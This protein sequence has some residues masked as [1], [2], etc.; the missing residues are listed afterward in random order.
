MLATKTDRVPAGAQWL[1]EVKWDGVRVLVDVRDGVVRMTSRNDNDVTPAWPDLSDPPLGDRDLLVD[2][3]VIALNDRGVPDFRVLQHRMHVRNARE[4]ARLVKSV[5]ATLMVFDLL[6]LDGVD[7]TDRPLEERRALLEEL[8]LAESRW[9]VP[10][11][12]DDGDMLF[13]ATLQQG[14]EGVVSKRRTSRYRFDRRSEDWRKLAHRHRGS[15]VVGGWRPQ[16]GTPDRLAALLVGEPT[17]DGLLYRGRVGSGIAGATSAR[18]AA[19][20][21]PLA[22]DASP[23]ADEVP[24]VD[25]AGTFWVEPRVVVDIDTH[26]LG[27]ERLRQPSFQGVRDD[28]SPEDLT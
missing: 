17:P 27:Y 22:T 13:E 2:G 10:A 3:E 28:L 7:L 5:P 20:L 25:A 4:V 24:R 15:F 16:V 26:G 9:Q 11:A 1:H 18:L 21:A 8:P 19:L 12:Y 23:F 6:R 14:L